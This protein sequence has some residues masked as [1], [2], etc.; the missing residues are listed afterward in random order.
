MKLGI[1]Q[2]YFLPYIGYFQLINAVDKFVIYDAI[3]YTKKSW[4]NRNRILVN[5]AA[6]YFTIPLRKDSDYLYVRDRYI[7]FN[8]TTVIS[9]II[10]RITEAYRKAPFFNEVMPITKEILS[11]SETNLFEYIKAS[12]EEIMVYLEISTEIILSSNIDFDQSL[13]SQ[14]KVLAICKA[15]EVDYYLNPI[16][17][18]SLYSKEIFKQ[19]NI[20][21]S[22][23]QPEIIDY[24]QFGNE[25]VP[26]LSIIDVM[27]FNDK[28]TIK[29]MLNQYTLS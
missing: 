16:G 11:S 3:E 13:K 10:N 9:K 12:I 1:M 21:L 7:A 18:M 29:S 22:F 27:M 20:E 2:P 4:I 14:N 6:V 17:G 26:W 15:L 19:K 28:E 25:F 5:G 8:R 23:I 24:I